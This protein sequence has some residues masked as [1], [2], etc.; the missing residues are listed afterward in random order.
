[1]FHY[2]LI[3]SDVRSVVANNFDKNYDLSEGNGNVVNKI[4]MSK[5]TNLLEKS[6]NLREHF[7]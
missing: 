4:K 2:S 3:L 6:L 5:R 7:S 1:M